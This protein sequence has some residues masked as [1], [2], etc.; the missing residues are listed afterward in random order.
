[1]EPFRPDEGVLTMLCG[2]CFHEVADGASFCSSCGQP[3]QNDDPLSLRV[4][5]ILNGRYLVGNTLGQGGFGITYKALDRV[6]DRVVAIKEYFPASIC[7]RSQDGAHVS[8]TRS[9]GD[10][11]AWG[12]DRFLKEAETLGRLRDVSG[13]AHVHEYFEEN[14]TAY[15]SM[16]YV[17]G[18]DLKHYQAQHGGRLTWQELRPI[19]LPVM[20]A[21]SAV[22]AQGLI[23][24]DV[25]PDNIYVTKSGSG[26][27]LDFGAARESMGN[28]TQTLSI[29]LK[30]NYAPI[31]QFFSQSRQGPYTDVYALGATIYGCLAGKVPVSSM[32][33]YEARASNRPDPLQPIHECAPVDPRLETAVLQAMSLDVEHRFQTMDAFR[34]AL[35]QVDD[36]QPMGDSGATHGTETIRQVQPVPAPGPGSR[37]EG[38]TG[39]APASSSTPSPVP[40]PSRGPEQRNLTRRAL[41]GVACAAGAGVVICLVSRF[42]GARGDGGSFNNGLNNTTNRTAPPANVTTNTSTT[43]NGSATGNGSGVSVPSN[44]ANLPGDQSSTSQTRTYTLVQQAMTWKDAEAYCENQGGHLASMTTYDEYQKVLD[45]LKGTEIRVCW[46]GG[47]RDGTGWRWTSGDD[48]SYTGWAPDEPNDEGGNEDYIALLGNDSGEWAWYD[49]PNDVSSFYKA[50]RIGFV[51]QK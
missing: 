1:M 4:G 31:E 45:Q 6:A 37:Q 28:R 15:F 9:G 27:L 17:D 10:D 33:R 8:T 32:D 43:G 26:V 5:S 21:L 30:R 46:V 36:P 22:H 25:S 13:I 40:A 7:R 50:H 48:F 39:P 41:V 24:R 11:F 44:D 3:L 42:L 29:V 49:C 51:M 12:R 14:G 38:E 19:V 23:H 34:L 47:Y 35:E 18:V 20:G 16:D 2:N